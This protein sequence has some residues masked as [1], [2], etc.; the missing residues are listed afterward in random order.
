MTPTGQSSAWQGDA[1]Q[2]LIVYGN[3]HSGAP[4]RDTKGLGKGQGADGGPPLGRGCGGPA[5]VGG[6]QPHATGAGA[7]SP[8]AEKHG[9]LA[10]L[11][12]RLGEGKQAEAR[13]RAAEALRRRPKEATESVQV[14]LNKAHWKMRGVNRKPE[15]AHEKHDSLR[16]QLAEQKTEVPKDKCH[17]T[18]CKLSLKDIMDRNRLAKVFNTSA[19]DLFKC[20]G[21]NLNEDHNVA[22]ESR[23]QQL[24][25]G[26]SPMAGA[27][28]A[29][30]KQ[31]M[32]ELRQTHAA[33]LKRPAAKRHRNDDD[34]EAETQAGGCTPPAA[35]Q[36]SAGA[37][38]TERPA[39]ATPAAA[40]HPAPVSPGAAAGAKV[41]GMDVPLQPGASAA[42]PTGTEANGGDP[43]A[44]PSSG[45]AHERADRIAGA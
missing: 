28:F 2:Q 3:G 15:A 17:T 42:A 37:A 31:K 34:E 41:E 6:Q 5:K 24:K 25:K 30:A 44:A 39:P 22:I 27:L 21:L 9:T 20:D 29:D 8:T 10:P 26:L 19:C 7:T 11:C 18:Q 45:S 14:R 43:T 33:H 1:A 23:A 16:C 35:T 38:A 4:A 32:D 13:R 36:P 40:G 12:D